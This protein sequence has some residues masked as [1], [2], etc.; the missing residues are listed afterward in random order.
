MKLVYW[1]GLPGRGE[2]VRLVLEEA[3]VPYEDVAREPDAV[4]T[5]MAACRG[6]LGGTPAFAPPILVDGELVLSQT[7]NLCRYVG[8]KHGLWPAD[9]ALDA[10]A[11]GVALTFADLVA[12]VHDTHHPISGRLSYEDQRAEAARRSAEFRRGRLATW[13]GWWARVLAHGGEWMVG[14]SR[15]AVD[16]TA[17]QALEGLRYA[18]PHAM[19][20]LEP[21]F[22][23]LGHHHDR[24]AAL[25]RVA[26]YLASDRRQTFDE[27]GIF[28]RY[29]E[30]DAA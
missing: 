22:P 5:V 10:T 27:S 21:R 24:V 28:R 14:P 13:L 29:P 26:A 4:E 11:L 3:G 6:E 7:V 8:L 1:P 12:E 17:F 23:A 16:L 20:S 30:L 25:P 15:T 19:A 2:F 9:P 18:F